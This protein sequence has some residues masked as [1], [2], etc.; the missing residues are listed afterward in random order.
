M[1][2]EKLSDVITVIII[3]ISK[4]LLGEDGQVRNR[5]AKTA[6]AFGK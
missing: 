1:N 5:N 6:Q 4:P 2:P 3:I